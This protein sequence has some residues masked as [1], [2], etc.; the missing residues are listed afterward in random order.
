M[1]FWLDYDWLWLTIWDDS[2]NP[3]RWLIRFSGTSNFAWSAVQKGR[4]QPTRILRPSTSS[5]PF[6][7]SRK[8]PVSKQKTFRSHSRIGQFEGKC[9]FGAYE[10]FSQPAL[11]FAFTPIRTMTWL[12]TPV[13]CLI[14]VSTCLLG[15]PRRPWGFFSFGSCCCQIRWKDME[16]TQMSL[17]TR[18]Y[19]VFLPIM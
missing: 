10:T 17:V 4:S 2:L 13:L 1:D 12:P 15:L 3:Q 14:M 8:S 9:R 11:I 7:H 16:L 5:R 6:C 19:I 18:N